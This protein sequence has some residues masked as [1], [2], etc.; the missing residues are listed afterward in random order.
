MRNNEW[1]FLS[2]VPR[3]VARGGAAGSNRVSLYATLEG[4]EAPPSGNHLEVKPYAISGIRTDLKADPTISND[5]Y[6]DAGLDLS[7][8]H[9]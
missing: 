9:I 4:I 1:I 8:I 2:P 6:A 3:S 5:S 7:L